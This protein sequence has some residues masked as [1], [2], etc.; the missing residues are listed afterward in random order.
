[1]DW[2]QKY[3]SHLEAAGKANATIRAARADLRGLVRW[4]QLNRTGA[5][6]VER[7]TLRDVRHWLNHRQQVDGVSPNTINRGLSSL[8]SYG[9]WAVEAGLAAENPADH[10]E[11]IPHVTLAPEG[12]MSIAVDELLR[13][14]TQCLDPIQRRRDEAMLAL[15]IYAGLRAQECCDVQ[16]RDVDIDGGTVVVRS[17]KGRRHRRVPLSDDAII[18]L[19]RYL[20]EVRLV[21]DQSSVGGDVEKEP[22]II[23]RQMAVIGQPW[24][25][26]IQPQSLRKHV[27]TL[28][29]IGA[30]AL[31]KLAAQESSVPKSAELRDAARQLKQVT[32]H[33]LRHSLAWRM[34]KNGAK[35][36]EVQRI[37]GH[38]R[39]STTGIYLNPSAD[40]LRSA[41]EKGS[42]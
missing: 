35:L 6:A 38:T 2:L 33:Q 25:P 12:L 18:L 29:K 19:Q 5:F 9:R 16:L 37:L 34:L 36:P 41:V 27:K 10:V 26:G 39:L 13:A 28:G 11:E 3:L 1:M 14:A 4:W 32:P 30:I 22:L 7:L 42:V 24:E 23:G 40:D 31:E 15:L 8:R 21:N 17:G 20:R